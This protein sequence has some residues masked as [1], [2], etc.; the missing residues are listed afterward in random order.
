ME[1]SYSA[2]SILWIRIDTIKTGECLAP[3]L[4]HSN[5]VVDE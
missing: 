5:I 4:K 3:Q 1:V 2:V